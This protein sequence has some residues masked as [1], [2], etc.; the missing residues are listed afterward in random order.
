MERPRYYPHVNSS[1]SICRD[2]AEPP[3]AAALVCQRRLR[4]ELGGRRPAKLPSP[5]FKQQQHTF[6]VSSASGTGRRLYFSILNNPSLGVEMRIISGNVT[7][8]S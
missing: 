3:S 6:L 2:A 4:G 1:F 8:Q 5:V 7:D